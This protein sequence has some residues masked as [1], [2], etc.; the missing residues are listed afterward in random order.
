MEKEKF[1]DWMNVDFLT[2]SQLQDFFL[3]LLEKE[4]AKISIKGKDYPIC[5][6]AIESESVFRGLYESWLINQKSFVN[7]GSHR[8]F[9]LKQ[10]EKVMTESNWSCFEQSRKK[11]FPQSDCE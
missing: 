10:T 1:L 3:D 4:A 9:D 11:S 2:E 7:F 6:L 8:W 5:T